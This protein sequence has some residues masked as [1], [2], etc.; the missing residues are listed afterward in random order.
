VPYWFNLAQEFTERWIHQQQIREAVGRVENHADHLPEVLRTFVWA[1]PHQLPVPAGAGSVIAV[2][3]DHLAM[4][5]LTPNTEQGWTLS[6]GL[7]EDP[8][9]TVAVSPDA[10][11]RWF[12]GAEVPA[13]QVAVTGPRELTDAVMQVRAIIV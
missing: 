2:T 10:A 9:A 3:I 4:W 13:D 12:V 7:G 1:L 11:W 8:T 5:T 6:E